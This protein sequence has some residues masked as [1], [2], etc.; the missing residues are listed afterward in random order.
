MTLQEMKNEAAAK[1]IHEA[2]M[3]LEKDLPES[4]W[5]GK[6]GSDEYRKYEESFQLIGL[7]NSIAREVNGEEVG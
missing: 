6:N 3:L 5:N 1:L 2:A 7:L 4:F